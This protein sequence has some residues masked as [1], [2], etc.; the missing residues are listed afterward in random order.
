MKV[1]SVLVIIGALVAI[2]GTFLPWANLGDET[3]TGFDFYRFRDN[4]NLVEFD[5]P[6]AV[7]LFFAGG[8][9]G[10]GIALFFAGRVLAVAIIAIIAS[11]IGALVGLVMIG[12]MGAVTNDVGGSIGYGVVLTI[13]GPLVALAGAI[14]ATAKRRRFS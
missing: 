10:L 14:T 5:T 11:A 8:L 9:V 2:L 6:G 3:G 13:L 4:S 12:L 7:V 1:G